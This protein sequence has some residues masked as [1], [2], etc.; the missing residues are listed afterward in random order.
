MSGNPNPPRW[1]AAPLSRRG[2]LARLGSLAGAAL[3]A[4]CDSSPTEPEPVVTEPGVRDVRA[5]GAKGDGTTDDTRAIL[6]ARNAAGPGGMVFFPPGTYLT[7]ALTMLP[8][9]TWSGASR[10]GSQ[11]AMMERGARS[12]VAME[13]ADCT[14]RD[15]GLT[16][17]HRELPDAAQHAV[18]MTGTGHRVQSCWIDT[19]FWWGVFIYEQATSCGVVDTEIDGTVGAHCVEINQSSYCFVERCH[20]RNSL[21]NGVEIYPQAEDG[22]YGIRVVGNRLENCVG[23]GIAMFGG[24]GCLLD[25][26]SVVGNQTHGI[27]MD[28]VEPRRP[29]LYPA[30]DNRVTNNLILNSGV[31]SG[32][33]GLWMVNTTATLV[34]G[35]TVSGSGNGGIYAGSSLHSLIA[36]NCTL[37]GRTGIVVNDFVTGVTIMGNQCNDNSALGPEFGHG[38]SVAGSAHTVTGNVCSDTRPVKLQEYGMVLSCSDSVVT[39]NVLSGNVRGGL[40]DGGQDNVTVGNTG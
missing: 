15:L 40:F 24:H 14:L 7:G 28:A 34:Q 9:Q 23:A 6:S 18:G 12:L 10:R 21:H 33:F 38:I 36:N 20:L 17:R 3:L 16:T 4:G 19:G 39:G 1:P 35:N 26:N 13:G 11:L 22:C 30:T 32:G 2:A 31:D 5:Y 25:G 27:L 8:G 29:E 37:N